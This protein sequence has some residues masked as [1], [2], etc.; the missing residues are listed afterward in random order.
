[1]A[2]Q[3]KRRVTVAV[4]LING[5]SKTGSL[6][7]F[8]PTGETIKI[9]SATRAPGGRLDRVGVEIPVASAS[10]VAFYREG[11]PAEPMPEGVAL[12]ET[13]VYAPGG[14]SFQVQVPLEDLED[15]VGFWGRPVSRA[16]LY[17]KVWFFTERLSAIED[18]TPLG[19]LLIK[20][21]LIDV[22]G[23]DDAVEVQATDREAPIG[24][25]LVEQAVIDL[26]KVEE[27][28]V[29]QPVRVRD[30]K[31]LRLGEILVEAGLATQDQIA[32]ALPEQKKRRGKRLG[33]VLV[34]AGIV[35]ESG[36]AQT[37]AMKFRVPYIDLDTVEVDLEA[38]REIPK[39]IIERFRV[40][41][42][43]SENK[44]L[45]VAMADPTAVEAL[46][47]VGLLAVEMFVTRDDQVIVNEVAPRPHNSGHWTQDACVT[48][49]FEQLV[50][51]GATVPQLTA[52]FTAWVERPADASRRAQ[53]RAHLLAT[54][55]PSVARARVQGFG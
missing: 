50:R 33:Q 23:L 34:E 53:E 31:R 25:I 36:L 11:A 51:A 35:S 45:H 20:Q 19:E 42:F 54:W 24:Q 27:A 28:I 55:L 44:V 39:G 30:G 1:M 5:T 2:E 15:P 32:Q 43:K 7:A 21:G 38:A 14:N 41:P 6:V 49:Q 16:T 29:A 4:G 8:E 40:L 48:S 10:Y 26:E 18:A 47:M 22:S 37:L 13:R 52:A 9:E 46:D 12:G 3:G 17:S